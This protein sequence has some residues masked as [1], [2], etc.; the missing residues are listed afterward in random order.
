MLWGKDMIA[1][2]T[3]SKSLKM[4]ISISSAF[5]DPSLKICKLLTQIEYYCLFLS[6]RVQSFE[7]FIPAALGI[8]QRIKQRLFR[9]NICLEVVSMKQ[10]LNN[11]EGTQ[12]WGSTSFTIFD[13][14]LM[15][16]YLLDALLTSL[17]TG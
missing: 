14:E 11:L 13:D 15:H 3:V 5:I 4:E 8:A 16:A 2:C 7:N 9:Y 17:L 12:G 6:S 1:L 10:R